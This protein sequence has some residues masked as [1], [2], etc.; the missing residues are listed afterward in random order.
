MP[1]PL[2][3]SP[4][5]QEWMAY[6]LN[7]SPSRLPPKGDYG[8]LNDC[9][10]PSNTQTRQI[11]G[12]RKHSGWPGLQRLEGRAGRWMVIKAGS[13]GDDK[14]VLWL[15]MMAAQ[16]VNITTPLNEMFLMSKLYK[17]MWTTSQWHHCLK[18][19]ISAPT[20]LVC[21]NKNSISESRSQVQKGI[22]QQQIQKLTVNT[23]K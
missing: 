12:D 19:C 20:H 10:C 8:H 6:W 21:Q 17:I 3:K 13:I 1:S 15:L 16:T 11:Y 9:G 2:L 5:C 22:P 18:N 14:S 7:I 4:S 23:W